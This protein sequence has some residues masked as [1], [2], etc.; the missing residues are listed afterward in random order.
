MLRLSLEKEKL[1]V[2]DDQTG[3][4]TYCFDVVEKTMELVELGQ[5]G[6][7]HV[8]SI[9]AITWYDLT[10]EIIRLSE[11]NTALKA[12]TS[13]EFPMKAKRPAYSLL[14][15]KKIE[16]LDLE[17]IGWKAGLKHLL[18]QLNELN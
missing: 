13:A 17:P 9:G 15:T 4:P 11:S 16:D 6:I 8:S 10:K 18:N 2:V 14:S 7:F 3:S 5:I 12:V 1:Q